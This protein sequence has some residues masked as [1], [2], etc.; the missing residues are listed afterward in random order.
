LHGRGATEQEEAVV[1]GGEI[2][3]TKLAPIFKSDLLKSLYLQDSANQPSPV[4][5]TALPF[6]Q[7]PCIFNEF[8][9]RISNCSVAV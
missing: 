4:V 9:I 3:L 1:L 2:L 5:S 6:S 7:G 8:K